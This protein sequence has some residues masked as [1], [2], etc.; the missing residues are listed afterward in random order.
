[1]HKLALWIGLALVVIGV[2]A[3]IGSGA[4]SLTALVPS[5]LG[6]ILAALGAL[7]MARPG[8]HRHAM[9]AA[10]AVALLGFFGSLQGIPAF[11]ALLG[12]AVVERPWAATAQ[13][14]TA[15]LS[16]VFV[17]AAISSF[18]RARRARVEPP[19]A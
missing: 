14:L 7:A 5:V 2:G 19:A 1:M 12:G 9:H 13:A 4:A 3:Y 11:F 15:L 10:A 18:V 6:A 16:A 8:A 17:A